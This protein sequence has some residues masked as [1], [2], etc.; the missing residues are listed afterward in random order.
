M[1]LSRIAFMENHPTSALIVDG[2]GIKY[3]NYK[4]NVKNTYLILNIQYNYSDHT[5]FFL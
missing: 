3:I 1:T 5:Y 2:I 4:L